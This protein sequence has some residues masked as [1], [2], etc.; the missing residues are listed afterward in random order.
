MTLIEY[1]FL[2]A[3]FAALLSVYCWDTGMEMLL[4]T[5]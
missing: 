1:W 2:S 5:E 3:P 4:P